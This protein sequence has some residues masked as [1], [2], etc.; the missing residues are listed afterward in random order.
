MIRD[1]G[2]GNRRFRGHVKYGRTNKIRQKVVVDSKLDAR[3][4]M[5]CLGDFL[6]MMVWLALVVMGASSCAEERFAETL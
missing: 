5:N 1:T 6:I 4:E 2:M 3:I